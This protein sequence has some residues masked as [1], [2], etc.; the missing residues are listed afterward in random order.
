MMFAL[1]HFIRTVHHVI[2]QVIKTKF[3]VGTVG[4]VCIVS[5]ATGIS[6]GFMLIYAIY[7]QAK[8]LKDGTVPL[9][10]P[11][12]QVIIH[13]YDVYA[14]ASQGVQVSRQSTH[15]RFTFTGS[16]LCNFTTVQYRT[17]N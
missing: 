8:P 17:T 16:H 2:S 6:I 12:S 1:Y 4:Y 13:R 15:Q 5:V 7:L 11:A 10:I 9:T 14:F 3:V